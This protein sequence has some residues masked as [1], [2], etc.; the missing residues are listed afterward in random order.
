MILVTAATG[1]LGRLAL[2]AL[3]E[4]VGANNVIAAVR[5]PE[6]AQDLA[7]QGFEVRHADYE[8]PASLQAALKGVEKVLLISSS[9]IGQRAPQH[10][11]V[12]DAAREQGVS[13]LAYTSI[14]NAT[15][16]PLA[17]AQ[18][19]AATEHALAAS[20]VPFVLLR[21]GWYLENHLAGARQ[22]V[23]MGAVFGAAED[24][25]FSSATRA[26][27]AQAAAEIL[28]RP[29]QAGKVYELAGSEGFTLTEYA[30]ALSDISGKTVNY[31]SFDESQ[32]RVALIDAGLPEGFAAILADSDAQ[33]AKGALFSTSQD[34]ETLL[35]RKT[36]S[37]RE[38]LEKTLKR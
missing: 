26:D 9:E 18:E 5:N 13:L 33:A 29:N 35:S 16:S 21:N 28:T 32:Y 30:A 11:A 36:T 3:A 37:M 24:G 4:K 10:Q 12:I 14:L 1:Q 6:K 8:K 27:F 17:L 20:G 34:L 15:S 38:A 22:A 19:H 31:T 7:Q 25:K 2:V 23:D